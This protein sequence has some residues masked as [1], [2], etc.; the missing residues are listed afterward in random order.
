MCNDFD[1]RVLGPLE[2]GHRQGVVKLP[3]GRLRVLL[4]CLVMSPNEVVSSDT[5]IDRLWADTPVERARG[6]LHTCVRRLRRLLCP[7]LVQTRPGGYALGVSVDRV[8]LLRFRDLVRR[9]EA[10]G[11]D[12]GEKLVLLREALALRRGDPFADVASPWLDHEVVPR[13]NEEWQSALMCRIDL[14]MAAGRHHELIPELRE[15]TTAHPLHEASWQRLILALHRCGRRAEALEAY[16][17]VHAILRDELALDPSDELRELHRSIL[18]GGATPSPGG[19]VG[20]QEPVAGTIV[21]P[22]VDPPAQS[23]PIRPQQLPP[24]IPCFTGRTTELATLDGLLPA[25]D[26]QSPQRTAIAVVDGA[27]GAGKTT[28]AVHWAHRVRDRFPD[29]QLYAD[30]RGYGMGAPVEPTAVLEMF[31]QALGVPAQQI[32]PELDGRSALLRSTLAD[33]RV[34]VLLDNAR[35]S[36]QVRPLLPGSHCLVLV[37]SRSQLRGLAVRHGAYRVSLDWLSVEE[38]VTLLAGVLGEDR[39]AAEP[40][41]AVQLAGLCA[42]MPLA[43]ALAAERIHH[44]PGPGNRTGAAAGHSVPLHDLVAELAVERDRLDVLSVGDDET[45]AVRDVFSWSYDALDSAAAAGAFRVLGLHSG[46]DISTEAAAVLIGVGPDQ[47]RRLL[48]GLADRGLL[49]RASRD[50]YRYRFHDLMR[51]YAA[52]R[53][54]AEESEPTRLAALH[55]VLSWYMHTADAAERILNPGHQHLPPDPPEEG[56]EPLAFSSHEEALRWCETERANLMAAVR[57]A[58]EVGEY[59]IAWR[60][61]TVLWGF[62]NLRKH[63]GD[64]IES[65]R[66]GLAAARAQGDRYGEASVLT[67]IGLARWDQRRFTEALEWLEEALVLRREI[68]DRWGEGIALTS[69]GRVRGNLGEHGRALKHHTE[70]LGIFEE[71]GNQ[72]GQ[73]IALAGLGRVCQDLN[74]SER[75]REHLLRAVGVFRRIGNRWGEGIALRDLCLTYAALGRHEETIAWCRRA[76]APCHETGS[77]HTRARI[78]NLLSRALCQ[79]GRSE[80][81]RQVWERATAIF[82]E[83]GDSNA[84]R[85]G[86]LL[87]AAAVGAGW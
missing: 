7:D 56:C 17:Q 65:H 43:L 51:L 6:A 14:E 67:S 31:L 9:S 75:A 11:D 42:H 52:E 61:P 77:R 1:F 5:L 18:D 26:G 2:V 63:W 83:L 81:A 85:A 12:S 20:E 30:L 70:A 16:Q 86:D 44:L 39:I 50:R 25:E 41:T 46:P 28:L 78:L 73:G 15:L 82:E 19:G 55:R 21:H 54:E 38:S 53:A 76:L 37:T 72:W 34:L 71:I 36:A 33:R 58:F 35:D 29:G 27:A 68:G 69:L 84:A 62:F 48:E 80:E 10:A 22:A 40:D 23:P 13:L 3:A 32:P 87:G 64:W 74:E 66:V 47:T 57:L 24:G 60:L 4:S 49:E 8:D 45:S 59:S 79:T